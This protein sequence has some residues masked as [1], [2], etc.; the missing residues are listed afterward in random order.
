M[1]HNT[2]VQNVFLLF[3]IVGHYHRKE[4]D[5][6]HLASDFPLL[7]SLTQTSSSFLMCRTQTIVISEKGLRRPQHGLESYICQ[8]PF[9]MLPPEMERIP[10]TAEHAPFLLGH[11][12]KAIA[13]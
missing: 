11:S 9:I 7:L 10:I 6:Y 4:Q 8:L 5:S 13:Y 3:P 2:F 12:K 1:K